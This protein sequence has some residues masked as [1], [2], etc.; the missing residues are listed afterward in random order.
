MSATPKQSGMSFNLCSQEREKTMSP[1][2]IQELIRNLWN[3]V[4][5]REQFDEFIQKYADELDQDFLAGIAATVHQAKESGNENAFGF[6]SRIGQLLLALLTPS[7]VLRRASLKS[8]QAAYLVRILLEKVNSPQDLARFAAEYSDFCDPCFFAVLEDR[9]ETEKARG[10][11]GNARFLRE[12]GQILQDIRREKKA[13]E[14]GKNN[15]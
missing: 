12:V 2:R 13:D 8:E 1:E 6:F 5:N 10:N 7:D 4:E 3:E 14:T 11:E 9:A 15:L